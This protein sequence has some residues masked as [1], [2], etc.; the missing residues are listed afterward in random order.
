MKLLTHNLLLCNKSSC[1]QTGV[2]NFPLKLAVTK[3]E[4]YDDEVAIPCT[5]PLMSR[6]AE[7]LD[8]PALQATVASVSQ[9][10]SIR[11]TRVP[12]KHSQLL[13]C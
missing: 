2:V 6:L 13:T 1:A 11:D 4:D 3:W 7:K 8:W 10:N 12:T 9:S 5:K